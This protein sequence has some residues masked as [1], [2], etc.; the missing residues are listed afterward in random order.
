LKLKE[1]LPLILGV[2]FA[3]I[4]LN[5]W[6]VSSLAIE[7]RVVPSTYDYFLKAIVV[8]FTAFFGSFSAF[9]LNTRKE[10]H[11]EIQNNIS[12][13]N[14]ALFVTL[15]QINSLLTLK[16]SILPLESDPIR[17]LKLPAMYASDHSDL[18]IDFD[19]MEFLLKD[20]PNLLLGLSIEQGRFESAIRTINM[21]AEFHQEDLQKA[22]SDSRFSIENPTLE[23]LVSAVGPRIVGV[24]KNLTDGTYKQIKLSVDSITE[25]HDELFRI[26]KEVFPNEPF[27]KYQQNA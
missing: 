21:R 27:I 14:A 1:I 22:L 4:L 26:A 17:F 12:A 5:L 13:L 2:L 10:K 20:H 7:H 6:Y 18:K 25:I 3:L 8:L 19:R 15:R 16:K 23:Q 11:N 9:H 24:A